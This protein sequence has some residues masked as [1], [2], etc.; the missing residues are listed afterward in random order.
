MYSHAQAQTMTWEE[1]QQRLARWRV[2]STIGLPNSC[3][4]PWPPVAWLAPEAGEV[5]LL[6]LHWPTRQPEAGEVPICFFA[7]APQYVGPV[8]WEVPDAFF[9]R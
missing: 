6:G 8:P 7:R 4:M 9:W 1:G 3:D 5:P 2:L